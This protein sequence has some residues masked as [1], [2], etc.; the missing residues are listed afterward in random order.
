MHAGQAPGNYSLT[1]PVKVKSKTFKTKKK[2][3][4]EA[5][6]RYDYYFLK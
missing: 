4:P 2:S 3:I 6:P 1:Q 5:P